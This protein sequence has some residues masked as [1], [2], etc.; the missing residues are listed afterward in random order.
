MFFNFCPLIDTKLNIR[1]KRGANPNFVRQDYT[2]PMT[3]AVQSE[4]S[5]EILQLLV[6]A[7]A[8]PRG[9]EKNRPITLAA[10]LGNVESTEALLRLGANIHEKMPREATHCFWLY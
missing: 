10:R 7:G 3:V 6:E 2:T 5:S 8:N 4:N 1:L 9:E